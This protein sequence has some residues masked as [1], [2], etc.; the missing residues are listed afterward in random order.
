MLILQA[1]NTLFGKA[2]GS[3]VVQDCEDYMELLA[4]LVL[5]DRSL[6]G[7][8]PGTV[9]VLQAKS[10]EQSLH[11][12]VAMSICLAFEACGA[13]LGQPPPACGWD[14]EKEQEMLLSDTQ[15]FLSKV[16]KAE[17]DLAKTLQEH[18]VP[19]KAASQIVDRFGSLPILEAALESCRSDYH[20]SKL[21]VD[22]ADLS[23]CAA[24][25]ARD[26]GT[27]TTTCTLYCVRRLHA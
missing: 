21:L 20:R 5:T 8:G 13:I 22:V 12:L 25:D 4:W 7:R 23:A 24:Q 27:S 18:D 19:S 14:E 16:K 1:D 10:M 15:K 26:A 3:S 17:K 2:S 6:A 9:R 11:L